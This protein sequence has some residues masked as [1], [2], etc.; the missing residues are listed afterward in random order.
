MY[1]REHILHYL[2]VNWWLFH[3]FRSHFRSWLRFYVSM[4]ALQQSQQ[5]ID[6]CL[7]VKAQ[8]TVYIV[9]FFVYSYCHCYFQTLGVLPSLTFLHPL[10]Y[11]LFYFTCLKHFFLL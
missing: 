9:F 5:G 8:S 11:L 10:P 7:F 1:R 4:S 3:R 2:L 6:V